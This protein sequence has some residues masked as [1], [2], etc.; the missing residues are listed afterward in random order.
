MAFNT[1]TREAA[2][3]LAQALGYNKNVEGGKGTVRRLKGQ[4]EFPLI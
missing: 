1:D 4:F 3:R 2:R